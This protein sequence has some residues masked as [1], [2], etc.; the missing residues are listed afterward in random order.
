MKGISYKICLIGDVDV[1]K[2]SILHR[3]N[4]DSL[5]KFARYSTI[6]A[7]FLALNTNIKD[8]SITFHIWDTAGQE[9]FK[10]LIPLYFKDTDIYIVVFDLNNRDT[11]DAVDNI[12]I[13]M[14]KK[15]ATD[16]KD[17]CIILIGNKMD[18][19]SENNINDNSIDEMIEMI[20]NK[21]NVTCYKV[22]ALTQSTPYIIKECILKSYDYYLRSVEEKIRQLDADVIYL[23]DKPK[24]KCSNNTSCA[25]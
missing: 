17:Y 11:L 5:D 6:G 15:N 20:C 2:T 24:K 8:K 13:P 7:S 14:I 18:L 16:E 3:L 21:Y 23:H 12:W 9:R 25:K 4:H 22:S 10:S 1:G 19:L